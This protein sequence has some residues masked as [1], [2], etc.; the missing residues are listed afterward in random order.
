[1]HSSHNNGTF[2]PKD[3]ATL[4]KNGAGWFP[5]SRGGALGR[6]R[7]D[8]AKKEYNRILKM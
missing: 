7:V 1:L 4:E 5:S 2:S 8:G 6:K 3:A